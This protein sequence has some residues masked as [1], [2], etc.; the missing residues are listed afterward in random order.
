MLKEKEVRYLDDEWIKLIQIAK[1]IGLTREEVRTFFLE[2]A[3]K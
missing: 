1:N 2:N 3:R